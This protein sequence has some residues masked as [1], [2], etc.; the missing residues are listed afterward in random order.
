MLILR[1][2]MPG[3]R[4]GLFAK[5]KV[6]WRKI[7]LNNLL[8]LFRDRNTWQEAMLLREAVMKQGVPC[9]KK[10]LT[11]ALQAIDAGDESIYSPQIIIRAKQQL[12]QLDFT[13]AEIEKMP[14]S[15][16]LFADSG[17]FYAINK[18]LLSVEDGQGVLSDIG[19]LEKAY[20]ALMDQEETPEAQA[21]ILKEKGNFR[22]ELTQFAKLFFRF[23]FTLQLIDQTLNFLDPSSKD[24]HVLSVLKKQLEQFG[25]ATFTNE[26]FNESDFEHFSRYCQNILSESWDELGRNPDYSLIFSEIKPRSEL[27]L[28][29]DTLSNS[30]QNTKALGRILLALRESTLAQKLRPDEQPFLSGESLF[31]TGGIQF[32]LSALSPSEQDKFFEFITADQVVA[33]NQAQATPYYMNLAL[34]GNSIPSRE[35]K[36]EHRG[37]LPDESG[38]WGRL[39]LSKE[40]NFLG[41]RLEQ[42]ILSSSEEQTNLPTKLTISPQQFLTM[43]K[44]AAE[45]YEMKAI[46]SYSALVSKKFDPAA[47]AEAKQDPAESLDEKSEEKT[48]EMRRSYQKLQEQV[49]EQLNQLPSRAKNL[50]KDI[51]KTLTLLDDLESSK[52][53]SLLRAAFFEK[54]HAQALREEIKVL[55]AC[56]QALASNAFITSRDILK[57]AQHHHHPELNNLCSQLQKEVSEAMQALDLTLTSCPLAFEGRKSKY[58]AHCV[59]QVKEMLTLLREELKPEEQQGLEASP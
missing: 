16:W 25:G 47:Q 4:T 59:T 44:E 12:L 52:G 50:C 42:E 10:E 49:V 39:S 11:T 27:E 56:N 23:Q 31:Q 29:K 54:A 22:E 57:A 15:F 19:P 9:P 36:A 41:L 6:E 30:T 5:E 1:T 46:Y 38:A 32:D 35:G 20:Q 58:V 43:K 55:Q 37:Q 24:Y 40:G 53:R 18:D 48:P 33:A 2:K 28:L 51:N 26:D 13:E 8:G 34:G 17:C 14:K 3:Q 45:R 7:Y 21:L